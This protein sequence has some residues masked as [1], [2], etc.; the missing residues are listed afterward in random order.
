MQK[1]GDEHSHQAVL[2]EESL[3]NDGP[4]RARVLYLA[5]SHGI[6]LVHSSAL[7]TLNIAAEVLLT[8]LVKDMVHAA[9]LRANPAK[10]VP[11]MVKD[12]QR[13]WDREVQCAFSNLAVSPCSALL[14]MLLLRSPLQSFSYVPARLHLILRRLQMALMAEAD[15]DAAVAARHAQQNRLDQLA[16]TQ[17]CISAPF[18]AELRSSKHMQQFIL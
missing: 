13:N 9:R 8:R 18:T 6:S 15:K 12:T 2:P 7:R 14:H 11:G 17:R 5:N 3:L 16:L 10:D 4:L 1:L